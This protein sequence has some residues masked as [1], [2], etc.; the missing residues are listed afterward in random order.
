MSFQAEIAC[1]E[2]DFNLSLEKRSGRKSLLYAHSA[3]AQG[4]TTWFNLEI[5][6]RQATRVG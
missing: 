5:D 4:R 6:F 2:S 1:L 3:V